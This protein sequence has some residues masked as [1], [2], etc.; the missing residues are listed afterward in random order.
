MSINHRKCKT[1]TSLP[2]P[3]VNDKLNHHPDNSQDRLLL[4]GDGDDDKRGRGGDIYGEMSKRFDK[5]TLRRDL[6]DSPC[7]CPLARMGE[8]PCSTMTFIDFNC[9]W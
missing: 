9:L 1:E 2:N 3:T 8:H 6:A 5:D 7:S 4:N